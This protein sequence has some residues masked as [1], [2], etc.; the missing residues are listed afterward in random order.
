MSIGG[1]LSNIAVG[2][3]TNALGDVAK[4]N[5]KAQNAV[6]KLLH[7]ET[8][9]QRR[10]R[11]PHIQQAVVRAY[12]RSITEVYQLCIFTLE[13]QPGEYSDDIGINVYKDSM[14]KTENEISKL[15]LLSQIEIPIQ[16]T[17]LHFLLVPERTT[18]DVTLDLNNLLV[19]KIPVE[20]TLDSILFRDTLQR[21]IFDLMCKYFCYEITFTEEVEKIFMAQFSVVQALEET[22]FRE[23]VLTHINE[24]SNKA[25][26]DIQVVRENSEK[27][28][29]SLDKINEKIEALKEIK[30][31]IGSTKNQEK[32]P[33]YT[34]SLSHVNGTVLNDEDEFIST[35]FD[36]R[37]EAKNYRMNTQC[38]EFINDVS[39]EVYLD[40]EAILH[41]EILELEAI[42]KT[43]GSW[44]QDQRQCYHRLK[45]QH[46]LLKNRKQRI[47]KQILAFLHAIT[48]SATSTSIGLLD[49]EVPFNTLSILSQN[50]IKRIIK[51]ELTGEGGFPYL[52]SDYEKV[53][54]VNDQYMSFSVLFSQNN[55]QKLTNEYYMT[56]IKDSQLLEI[57]LP[58]FVRHL[59]DCLDTNPNYRNGK[60]FTLMGN[61]IISH[62]K[63]NAALK[64]Q[65]EETIKNLEKFFK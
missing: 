23:I 21:H 19:S 15:E 58:E 45:K 36:L 24:L 53:S 46:A 7:G 50:I 8:L 26:T 25:Q 9:E 13:N 38:Y 31:Y 17:H 49:Y 32:T 12:L 3:F 42:K 10:L 18:K 40:S 47:K 20:Y 34:L 6:H 1:V 63:F 43:E 51:R 5:S 22:E 30:K 11:N 39:F 56:D 2:L 44:T 37:E 35:L 62:P 33:I 48:N 29:S 14:K 54:F 60:G 28:L 65:H 61:W 27:I 59:V 64:K 55:F 57:I 41:K 52:P 4:S 16:F